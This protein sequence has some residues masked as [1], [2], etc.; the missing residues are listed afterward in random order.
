MLQIK[1]HLITKNRTRA[2]AGA[3]TFGCSVIPNVLEV[4]FVLIAY[5]HFEF[6]LNSVR[7]D[8][9]RLRILRR[10]STTHSRS[11]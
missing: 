1:T 8:V 4:C 7:L 5:C 2:G 10:H 9:K 3:I 11:D 6:F